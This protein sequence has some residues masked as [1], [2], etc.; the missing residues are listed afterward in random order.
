M[1]LDDTSFVV[2]FIFVFYGFEVQSEIFIYF[3][4]NAPNVYKL[5]SK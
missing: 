1:V 3:C 2:V 4:V 5:L